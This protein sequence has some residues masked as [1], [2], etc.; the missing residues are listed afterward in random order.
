MLYSGHDGVVAHECIL[1]LRDLTK[2]SGV[3]VDD[4]AK[5]LIDYGFHAPTMSFPVAG[6]LMVEPTESEDRYE[7][8]RFCDAM[9]AI[10]HEI[11]EV[12]SGEVAVADSMLRNAPHTAKALAG[13]WEY[14]YERSAA[15]FPVGV[16]G[17]R[18]VLAAGGSDRR[19]VR[20]PQPGLQLPAAGGVRELSEAQGQ[21]AGVASSVLVVKGVGHL[22]RRAALGLAD[23]DL[24][25]DAGAQ[26]GDVADH[27][28][29]AATLAQVV[30][31]RHHLLEALVV[32]GAE[33]LVDEEGLQVEA[34][35]LLADGIGQPQRQGQGGHERLAAGQRGR[36]PRLTGPQVEH[37]EAEAAAGAT[38]GEPVGVAQLVA[39]LAHVDS[40]SLAS[41]ATFSSRAARTKADSRIRSVVVGARA[42]DRVGE[43]PD[44]LVVRPPPR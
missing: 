43:L 32:E 7:I 12:E 21:A 30:E 36:G 15:A 2:R 19:R 33:A 34:T 40:R 11:A 37:L 3:T 38:R 44:D 18:Q 25:R 8:D 1:D 13:K 6:T 24:A 16:D 23:H 27:A 14:P 41:V 17:G 5:R 29:G 39:A 42:G 4:V 20:R 26:L 9:I 28:H 22:H 35:G 31:D 10:R